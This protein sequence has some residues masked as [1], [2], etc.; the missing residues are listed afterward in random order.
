[1]HPL[2]TSRRRSFPHAT[3][4][5]W[6]PTRAVAMRQPG[7]SKARNGPILRPI[8]MTLSRSKSRALWPLRTQ[9]GPSDE[10]T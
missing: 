2:A 5:R 7:V 1:M 3:G 8:R 6:L 10:A 4:R 9:L